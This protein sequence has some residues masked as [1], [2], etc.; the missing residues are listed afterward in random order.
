[1]P[2]AGLSLAALATCVPLSCLGL[3]RG[4]SD[5]L[6]LPVAGCRW[7]PVAASGC[8]S[9][10]LPATGFLWVALA[11]PLAVSDASGCLWLPLASSACRLALLAAFACRLALPPFF[12]L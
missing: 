4:A 9:R 8:L 3:P 1:M 12:F 6:W 5:F 7:V 2:V 10:P 11:P